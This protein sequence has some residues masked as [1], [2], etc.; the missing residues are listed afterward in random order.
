MVGRLFIVLTLSLFL[1]G[2]TGCGG[3]DEPAEQT[4]PETQMEETTTDTVTEQSAVDQEPPFENPMIA[5]KG[6]TVQIYSFKDYSRAKAAAIKFTNR[7]YKTFI[8]D[9]EVVGE[10]LYHRIRI[11]SFST[12]REAKRVC[13]EIKTRYGI[14]CWIDK[15]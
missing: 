14:N 15:D 4:I 8:E 6:Y 13:L 10:G 7:G 2:I 9:V 1:I 5:K 11:G 3:K 12:S